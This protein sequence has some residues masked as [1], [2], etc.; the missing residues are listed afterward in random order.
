[1]SRNYDRDRNCNRNRDRDRNRDRG[2][3]NVV[4]VALLLGV[5]AASM[6]AL[7][8]AVGVV[9]DS[10]ATQADADRV[11]ADLETAVDPVAATGPQRGRVTFAEGRLY[12]VE[13][14]LKVRADGSVVERLDVG[15]L[16]YRAGDRRVALHAGA[17]VRGTG[18]RGW[19]ETEPP[20]TVDDD[21]LIVGAPR[22]GDDV[23]SAA[24]TGG[25]TATVE[26]NVSHDRRSLGEATFAVAVETSAPGA[27]ERAFEELGATVTRE[28]GE[29]PT[30][31]ATFD[32]ERT[33]YLVVHDLDAEVSAGG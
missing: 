11:A 18:G 29:P 33:G 21:V 25:V 4:A 1:M 19:L 20:V 3:S 5:A 15:A 14:T 12:A 27:W 32:G 22:L 7:T 31:V 17:V 10:S 2:Q 28:P 13:R 26:T 9:V 16:V 6:G 8:A 24:G 23:G 30:V